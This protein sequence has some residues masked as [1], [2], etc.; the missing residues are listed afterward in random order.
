MSLVRIFN[1]Q[2]P[3]NP[4]KPKAWTY[5]QAQDRK[6]KAERAARDLQ[7]DD[8]R[9]DGIAAMSVEDYAAERG[10]EINPKRGGRTMRKKLSAEE[11]RENPITA[12][13]NTASRAVD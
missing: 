3:K 7:G 6:E 9:A 5:E 1:P 11:A 12:A 10:K 2:R 8:E 4:R 13:L